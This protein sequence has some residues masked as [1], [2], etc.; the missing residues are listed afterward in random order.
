MKQ[1]NRKNGI[2]LIVILATIFG[3][4][5]GIVGGLAGRS[6][7]DSYYLPFFG[8]INFSD[9]DY[10]GSTLIIR[11]A[12]KV[13]VEQD[14]KMVEAINSTKASTV[15]V[16]KKSA[17]N[18]LLTNNDEGFNLNG[19]YQPNQLFGQGLI[20]TS[21]GWIIT[22][23]FQNYQLPLTKKVKQ[24]IAANYAVIAQN[25][26]IYDIDDII[27]D[28]LTGFAFLHVS[29]KDLP[30][31]KFADLSK[32]ENGQLAATVNWDNQVWTT[33]IA[34]KKNKDQNI[35]NSSDSF[36]CKIKLA[37]TP[38]QGFN[39]SAL[40]NLAGDII[41]MINNKS[42]VVPIS[43]FNSAIRSLLNNGEIKRA[44]LGVNYISLSDLIKIAPDNS[45]SNGGVNKGALIYKN[46]SGI[47]I[48]KNS[49]ADLAGL[50]EG[51]IITMVDN[52]NINQ[53]NNLTE[54]IQQ[55]IAGEKV[56]LTYFREGEKHEV[57]VELGELK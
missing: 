17:K 55:F 29:S 43:Y 56:K 8:E 2:M 40:F 39:G 52:V 26:D 41:G 16:F 53:D 34:D 18:L 25:K 48:A 6:Y 24:E 37:K 23:L 15:G 50:K 28:N 54:A 9:R 42:E 51:D 33:V 31:K 10:R 3:L 38:E 11:D 5:S 12:K 14:V 36:S 19:Y 46:K 13:I 7:L 44:N 57:E 49:A 32:I 22:S 21:D 35:V 1:E 30:V 4:L 47:S 45:Y 27:F 20:I